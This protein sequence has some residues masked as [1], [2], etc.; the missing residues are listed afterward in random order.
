M[1]QRLLKS[2]P[3]MWAASELG[4]AED[5]SWTFELARAASVSGPSSKT[6]TSRSVI[7]TKLHCFRNHC[8]R[9]APVALSARLHVR[10]QT[11]IEPEWA[12]FS[13]NFNSIFTMA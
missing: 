4:R 2:S 1:S 3:C 6:G 5:R 7:S 11:T 9:R 10:M 13:P 12:K 8:K